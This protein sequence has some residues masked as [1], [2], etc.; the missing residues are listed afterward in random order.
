LDSFHR[1]LDAFLET[2][3]AILVVQKRRFRVLFTI[4][5]DILF[6]NGHCVT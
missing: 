1:V 5:N 3:H 4:L 6:Q 2:V